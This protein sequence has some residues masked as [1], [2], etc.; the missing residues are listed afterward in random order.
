MPSIQ[1]FWQRQD[2][3][4]SSNGLVLF[5]CSTCKDGLLKFEDTLKT[6]FE[7]FGEETPAGILV[8]PA[9]SFI[10]MFADI[11]IIYK[12]D[13]MT[14]DRIVQHLLNLVA[15]SDETNIDYQTLMEFIQEN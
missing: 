9:Q 6:V 15:F 10:P 13:D 2:D 3:G 7:V 5:A 14:S 8:I 4:L 12:L 1:A 11:S